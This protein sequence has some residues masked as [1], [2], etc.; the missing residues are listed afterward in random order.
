[1][2]RIDRRA[3]TDFAHIIQI[4]AIDSVD[5]LVNTMLEK[6]QNVFD[7]ITLEDEKLVAL[8]KDELLKYLL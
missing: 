7:A 1:M 5:Q 2:D 6:R 8:G 4:E 3:N